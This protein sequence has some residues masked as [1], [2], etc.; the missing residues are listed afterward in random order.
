MKLPI[1]VQNVQDFAYTNEELL[2]NPPKGIILQFFGLGDCRRITEHSEYSMACAEKDLLLVFP[3]SNPWSWMNDLAVRTV[4]SIV[5]ALLEKYQV[6]SIPIISTG[7][8]MGGLSCLIYPRYSRHPI[9]ACAANCPVCDLPYH[10]TERPDLPRTIVS[11]LAHYDMDFDQAMESLSPLHQ[12]KNLPDIPYLIV[13]CEADKSVNLEKHSEKMVAAMRQAGKNLV[14]Y[15]VPE[16]GH[17][18]LTPEYWD[19]YREFIFN[20]CG[21]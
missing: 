4:D 20:A 2:K 15:S 18:D 17:C 21:V 6:S 19:I 8:S 14:Y 10:F 13:H 11:A 12:V 7:G 1:H 5:T 3:Y 9:A 16:R